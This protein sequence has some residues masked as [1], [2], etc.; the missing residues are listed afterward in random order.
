MDANV[1]NFFSFDDNFFYW[2]Q[3]SSN[4]QTLLQEYVYYFDLNIVPVE[5]FRRNITALDNANWQYSTIVQN[6]TRVF[7]FTETL[8]IVNGVKYRIVNVT[9]INRFQALINEQ[10]NDIYAVQVIDG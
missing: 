2:R 9:E 1:N 7:I 6:G 5:V 3:F 4:N 10:H 8:E